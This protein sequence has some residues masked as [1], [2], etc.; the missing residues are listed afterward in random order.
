MTAIPAPEQRFEANSFPLEPGLRLLEASAGTGKTFALAQLVLRYVGEAELDLRQLLVVTFTDAAAAELR[1]RIG[2]R[3]QRALAGLENPELEAPDP[4]LAAWL[5]QQR[6]R[7]DRLRARL[8]LALE[9]LDGADI[10]TI[11]GFCRRTLQRHAL[12]AGLPPEL[13]LETDKGTLVRQV[14]HNYWQQQVLPLASHLVA[15]LQTWVK[16]PDTLEAL[17]GSLDGD[18]ALQ[19]DPLPSGFAVEAP[20][21]DQLEALWAEAWGRFQERWS[22]HGRDLEASFCSAAAAWR[23]QGVKTTTP[24]NPNP[25]KDRCG[26]VDG[27]IAAQPPGG[28]YGATAGRNGGAEGLL[29]DYFHPGA[30]L[31]VARGIEGQAGDDGKDAREP[32]LPERPL[33]EAV[34]QLLEGPAEA[35]VLHACHWGRAELNRRRRQSGRLGF[36]QLL[37]GL[38]PGELATTP[39]LQAVGERYAVALV[40]EFQDTDPVQWRILA[41]A[42][43][44]ERHRL[45]LVGDPKQAIY[46]FRGGDL[47]TYLHARQAAEAGAGLSSLTDNYRSSRALIAGLNGLMQPGL[48]RTGLAVPP[49]RAQQGE[50]NLAL[51]ADEHPLQLLWLGGDRSAGEKPPSRTAL[52]RELPARIASFTA[53][54]LNRGLS[55]QRE[56]SSRP[57]GPNDICLLVGTHRQADAL[58]GALEGCGIASRLVSQGDVFESAGATAL[59]RLLD[60]LA[61]PGQAHR[62]RLLAASPLLGWSAAEIAGAGPEEWS[63]LAGRLAQW[64][65]QLPRRGLLGVLASLLEQRGL[66]RLSLGGRLLAD[67]Q[68]CGELVA[69]RLHADQL[70]PA[71]AAD[72][73]RRLRLDPDQD[74]PDAHQPHSDVVDAAVSVV[75]VHRSKGLEYPVVICPYL[76]QAPGGDRGGQGRIGVRWRPAD[77]DLERREAVLD[78]HLN[79]NWGAGYGA[80]R[81]QRQAELEERERLA[82]VAA[83]RA[84]L[85]LV[86]AWGPVQ[87]QQG[88]PLHPWLFDQEDPPGR[89]HDPYRDGSDADWRERLEQGIRR[90]GLPLSLIDPPAKGLRIRWQPASSP[91]GEPLARG[92]VPS[93]PFDP[94]WGRSSYTSWTLGSHSAAPQAV[95]EGRETDALVADLEAGPPSSEDGSQPWPADGPLADFPRG[96]QAG[97]CLHRILEQLDYCQPVAAQADLCARELQRAGIAE[98]QLQAVVQ[99]L[100]QLRQTPLGG[101]LGGFQLAQLTPERRL[102]EMNFDLPLGLVR[103]RA[104]ARPFKDHPKGWFGATYAERL[105]ELDVASQGFLT[106]SIDLVFRH[107]ERWWVADWKSNW[108]GERDGQGQPLRCGPHHY[109]P[110]AMAELMAANHYPLQAHLY[111]V[112]L[113]R[114]LRWRLPG[115]RPEQH[116]GGYVYVFLRGVPGATST[117][118]AV[119]GMFLEQPPL[120]R[121]LALDQ[122]LGGAR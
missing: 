98:A 70:G 31:K 117:T 30:F 101:A 111:L 6:P 122:V 92:P 97:D 64:A 120:A 94:T 10:T 55:E 42:F 104:L 23:E 68:Q 109:A 65:A 79:G 71:A 33:L 41:G 108:L 75:T 51:A 47:R 57:L 105:A 99:G 121:L 119:P 15:G 44:P 110:P 54:L 17:L 28:D 21:A 50:T 25:R 37:E 1:D 102:N 4:T 72:W 63:T 32:S 14:A 90:R 62:L 100:E 58:R 52:E 8:L 67:L 48:R 11:H 107:G 69:A 19:L 18:P 39:L 93:Q 82:Y 53:N 96:A 84:R 88:N 59:Q 91:T 26:L 16:G 49:V 95:E 115:Y 118:G 106:G 78:L 83:T 76:W 89:D 74:V 34:A 46:R 20:L 24:Y 3:L 5:D 86:L 45:V 2:Q 22:A 9:E 40:D 7:S 12:E 35:M 77:G 81:Q 66:A 61:E 38:D 36:A 27:W 103:A 60:A 80:R 116:L 87:G 112:A 113:H 114:Y 29:R 73:L 43:Q 56:A 85:L 13:Q